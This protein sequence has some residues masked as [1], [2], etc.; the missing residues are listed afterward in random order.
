[1]SLS[2]HL[3]DIQEEGHFKLGQIDRCQKEKGTEIW[4]QSPQWETC[5]LCGDS[6]LPSLSKCTLLESFK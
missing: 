4:E 5:Q 1:M 3:R 2:W 6:L